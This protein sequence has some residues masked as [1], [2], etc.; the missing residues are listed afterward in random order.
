MLQKFTL[1]FFLLYIPFCTY[2]Q[3][4]SATVVDENNEPVLGASVYFDKTT[5]GV[6]T[7]SE[8][9]FSI[10]VPENIAFPELVISYMGYESIVIKNLGELNEVYTL[11]LKSNVLETVKLYTQHFSREQMENAFKE[12]FLG[13]GRAAKDCEILN[14]E[15]LI[16]YYTTEDN[17]LHAEAYNP[18]KVK[19][20]YLGYN[21]TFDLKEFTVSFRG[22]SITY[23]DFR[24]SYYN[25]YSFYEDINSD[26]VERRN[27]T[28]YGSKEHFFKSLIDDQI[29]NTDYLLHYKGSFRQPEDIFEITQLNQNLFEISL[30]KDIS[31]DTSLAGPVELV[32]KRRKEHT[33]VRFL[34]NSFFVDKYGKDLDYKPL[35]F[36]GEFAQYKV[37]R[38]L[39]SNFVVI[40]EN[41]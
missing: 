23:K 32:V 4:L 20:D 3:T 22:K 11:K 21:I 1:L 16:L 10:N 31:E 35:L 12:H 27:K 19:N 15:D 14:M 41:N 30:Q 18:I 37:A 28:Y 13:I 24:Q 9:R 36:I 38:T 17:T 5:I 26:L 25:G 33:I 29:V 2:S 39:P 6:V 34:K 8:G 7:N 40:K